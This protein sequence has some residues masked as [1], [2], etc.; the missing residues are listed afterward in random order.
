MYILELIATI[1]TLICVYLT[2][3]HN[4]W[5]WIVGII[6]IIAFFILFFIEKLYFQSILQIIFL[7][8]SIYGWYKW[9]KIEINDKLHVKSIGLDELLNDSFLIILLSMLCG[10]YLS[11]YTDGVLPYLDTISM[12][13]SILATYYLTNKQIESW[14]LWMIVNTILFIIAIYQNLFITS[15]LEIILFFI[16]LNAYIT[17]KKNLKMDCA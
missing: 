2:A 8:Q 12:G 10:S 13:L 17:W 4:I 11:E 14:L 9:K 5:C 1:F 6:G 7:F 15:I 16:S 3:K